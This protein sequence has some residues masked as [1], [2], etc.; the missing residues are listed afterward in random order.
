MFKNIISWL[1]TAAK[2]AFAEQLTNYVVHGIQIGWEILKKVLTTLFSK[3]RS[4]V[5]DTIEEAMKQKPD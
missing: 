1:L 5:E 3:F 2:S 4:T